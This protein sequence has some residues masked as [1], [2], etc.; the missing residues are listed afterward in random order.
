MRG[1]RVEI[2]VQLL[3]ILAMVPLV[4]SNTKETLLEDAILSVPEREREAETLMVV[5]DTTE[6]VLAPA[7]DTRTRMLM[8]KVAPG[9]PVRRVVLAD[10]SLYARR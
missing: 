9:I 1:R 2:V 10:G 6:T 8:R 7:V 4:S 5:G 3:D